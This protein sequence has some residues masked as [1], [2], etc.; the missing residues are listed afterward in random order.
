MQLVIL[1]KKWLEKGL[2]SWK[3]QKVDLYLLRSK[4][5]FFNWLLVLGPGIYVRG[6]GCFAKPFTDFATPGDTEK[7]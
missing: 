2:M 7:T 5:K 4:M 6:R 1:Y 3:V